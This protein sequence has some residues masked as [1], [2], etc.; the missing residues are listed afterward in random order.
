V[1]WWSMGIVLYEML[2]GT[3][4]FEDDEKDGESELFL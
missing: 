3:T 1:D 4:P 2:T